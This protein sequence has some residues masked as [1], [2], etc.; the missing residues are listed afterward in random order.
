VIKLP[1]H[2]VA[3]L[4]VLTLVACS[5]SKDDAQGKTPDN[6]VDT[7]DDLAA[8]ATKPCGNNPDP[9]GLS[10]GYPGDEY[11]ILPPPAGKGIQIHFGPKSYTDEAEVAKYVLKAG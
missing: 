11:C 8:S 5:S 2:T 9:C 10:S 7:C 4:F 6:D 3:G 1:L